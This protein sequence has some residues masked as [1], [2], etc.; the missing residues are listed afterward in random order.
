MRIYTEQKCTYKRRGCT[1][2]KHSGLAKFTAVMIKAE[3]AR[4][5]QTRITRDGFAITW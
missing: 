3:R 2:T 4:A 5:K 1:F